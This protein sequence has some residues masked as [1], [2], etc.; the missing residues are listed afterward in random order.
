MN[1]ITNTKL[2]TDRAL[3]A[4][5][6]WEKKQNR[7]L[8]QED[9]AELVKGIVSELQ[10]SIMEDRE[11]NDKFI[12]LSEHENGVLNYY[13]GI[14]DRLK[15]SVSDAIME[16]SLKKRDIILLEMAKIVGA[17]VVEEEIPYKTKVK[18]A[19]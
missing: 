2:P 4:I 3:S 18:L 19:I 11:N 15:W 9:K 13:L 14:L 6:T 17:N 8:S 1:P 16:N 10:D 5:R 7:K 12:A